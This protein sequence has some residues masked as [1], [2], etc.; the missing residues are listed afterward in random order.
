VY[1]QESDS[2]LDITT[3]T[4]VVFGGVS[5]GTSTTDSG[6]TPEMTEV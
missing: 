3:G 4:N 5:C 2:F 1:P 6:T